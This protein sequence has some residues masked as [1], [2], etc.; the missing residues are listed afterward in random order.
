MKKIFAAI[1]GVGAIGSIY[2]LAHAQNFSPYVDDAG[3]I[4]RPVDFKTDPDWLHIGGWSVVNENNEGNGVHNVYTTR[5]AAASFRENGV[6]PDG[7]PLV[8]EVRGAKG[9]DLSTGRAHWATENQ[10]WFVSIKD[11]KNRFSDNPL[12]GDGWGW[13]LFQADNPA[14]QVASDYKADCK[15]CHVPVEKSDWMYLHAYAPVLGPNA[16]KNAPVYTTAAL[17][18]AAVEGAAMTASSADD[19]PSAETKEIDLVSAEKAFKQTCRSCH[20]DK[21]GG[22]GI[23]PSLAGV[24]GREAGTVDGYNYS[25]ALKDSDVVWTAETIDSHITDVKGFIPKNRMGTMFPQG[26]KDSKKR[27]EII[28]YLESIS[29]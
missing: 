25:K 27:A 22:R 28:A 15:A 24:I 5:A 13:A 20:S 6:F 12:W 16:L 9:D 26:V 18:G 10:V 23:G 11:S 17:S 4:S 29:Q 7:A 14:K 2:A 8:K 3:N 19:T 1:I 21:A